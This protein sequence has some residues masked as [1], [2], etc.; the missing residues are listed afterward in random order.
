MAAHDAS[1]TAP[2]SIPTTPA[3]RRRAVASSFLG[4]TVEYYDFLLYGAAAGLVF[5]KLFFTDLDPGLALLLSY[6]TLFTGYIS[7]PLGGLLFGH[8]G[9]KF[10]RKNMLVITLMMMGLVSIAV[11]LMPTAA[12]IGVAAPILLTVLRVIQGF[13]VGGEWAGAMLMSMEY[14][15]QEKRGVGASLAVAGAPFGAVMATLVLGLFA[16]LPDEQFLSWGWRLP[17]LFSVVVVMLGLFLRSRVKESPDFEAARAAG[18]VH[19]GLPIVVLFTKYGREVVLGSLAAAAPLFVQG[20]LAV[21]MVPFVV[22][23]GAMGRDAALMWL[24]LSNFLHVFTIP[25]FAWLSDKFGRKQ[26]MIAGAVFAA[27][28]IWPMFLMFTSGNPL[29][30]GLAFL[31]GNPLIQAAMYGPIGAFLSELFDTGSRY[32]GVSATYQLGSLLGAGTAPIVATRL[33]TAETGTTYLAWFIVGAYVISGLA[34]LLSRSHKARQQS[35]ADRFTES[36]R[37]EG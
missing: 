14:S 33:V 15:Q 13:A 11:G 17:F 22:E 30:V 29:V 19:T 20:L 16:S 6:L 5:P 10:G 23:Q 24:T 35:H 25:F 31:M 4:Q 18:E 21:F 32:S 3:E 37:F 8:F 27:V 7:R 26:V 1:P 34:V 2:T 12:T 36:H 28:L 9:D